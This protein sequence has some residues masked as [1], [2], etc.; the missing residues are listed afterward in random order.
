MDLGLAPRLLGFGATS[1]WGWRHAGLGSRLLRRRR[2]ARRDRKGSI[3]TVSA[4]T[5]KSAAPRR[6]GRIGKQY[7]NHFDKCRCDRRQ[8]I[9]S[10]DYCRQ[11][12]L[13]SSASTPIIA[14]QKVE[15]CSAGDFP[16]ADHNDPN[17]VNSIFSDID[18]SAADLYDLF[19][20]PTDNG[21]SALLALTFSAKP[22]AGELD[23]DCCI[24]LLVTSHPRVVIPAAR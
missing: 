4:I 21:R 5:A 20:F 11:C 16:M 24:D 7:R 15:V 2:L 8:K 9:Q 10:I 22:K 12:F 1:A 18:Y 6:P 14:G 23:G 17:A 3:P 13:N 19:G